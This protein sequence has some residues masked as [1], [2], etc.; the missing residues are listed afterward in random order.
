MARQ[1]GLAVALAAGGYLCFVAIFGF[2]RRTKEF[3]IH[4]LSGEQRFL[5][6]PSSP[7]SRHLV[8]RRAMPS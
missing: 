4:S 2:K 5:V 8:N 3:L 6:T 7:Y 1:F